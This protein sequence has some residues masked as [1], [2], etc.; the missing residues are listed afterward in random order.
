MVRVSFLTFDSLQEGVGRSQVLEP[1]KRLIDLGHPVTLVTFEKHKPS[2]DIL[3]EIRASGANWLPKDFGGRGSLGGLRRV[4]LLSRGIPDGDVIHCRSDLPVL[5]YRLSGQKIPFVWD[6]RSL[7]A[8]QR[9]ALGELK[10]LGLQ[11]RALRRLEG[12]CYRNAAGIVTLTDHAL[13]ELESRYGPVSV[14]TIVNPTSVNLDLFTYAPMPSSPPVTL[15]ASGSYNNFYD[16][17]A[18]RRFVQAIRSRTEVN[19][20]WARGRD[21]TRRTLGFEDNSYF[22]DFDEMPNVIRQSHAGISICRLDA[23]PSLRAAAPTKNAEFLASG[24][25]IV[26]SEGLGDYA[27]Q[28]RKFG[29][30]VVLNGT[31]DKQIG[32]CADRLLSLL[33][34]PELAERCRAFADSHYSL[35]ETSQRLAGL[36]RQ[37]IAHDS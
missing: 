10:Q 20:I 37:V 15:L 9:V 30:G 5:A 33:E 14:P 13:V 31:S 7:W 27:D 17:E 25:P 32:E 4:S 21:A 18:S 28:V 29:V 2:E 26:V 36:Y 11:H 16:L 34:E 1:V 12:W 22:A 3:S 35:D 8:D 23:G 19:V 6:V 24:R